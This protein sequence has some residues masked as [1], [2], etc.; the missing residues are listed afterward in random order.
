MEFVCKYCNKRL[1]SNQRL[2]T[3]IIK[4]HNFSSIDKLTCEYCGEKFKH[5]TNKIRH[6]KYRCIVKKNNDKTIKLE[7][8]KEKIHNTEV[9]LKKLEDENVKEKRKSEITS[10]NLSIIMKHFNDAPALEYPTHLSLT[11]IQMDYLTKLES[12]YGGKYILNKLYVENIPINKRSVWC[13][14][15][16]RTNFLIKTDVSWIID[17]NAGILMRKTINPVINMLEKYSIRLHI[18]FFLNVS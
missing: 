15:V 14:D 6:I 7:E 9:K 18:P 8:L 3:H 16:N 17:K 5:I 11:D 10:S 13:C 4:I 1:S 2:K 12:V